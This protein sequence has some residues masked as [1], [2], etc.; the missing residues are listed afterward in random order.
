M[1]Y[2]EQSIEQTSGVAYG[3]H[4][5]NENYN[6]SE[7]DYNRVTIFGKWFLSILLTDFCINISR[8]SIIIIMLYKCYP[9]NSIAIK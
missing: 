3:E 5:N 8:Y 2:T 1:W 7:F 4:H 6:D 9:K